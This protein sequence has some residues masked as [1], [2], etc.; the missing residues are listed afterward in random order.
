[1]EKTQKQLD[2][3]Q[4]LKR[5]GHSPEEWEEP[6]RNVYC[7]KCSVCEGECWVEDLTGDTTATGPAYFYTCEFILN[8]EKSQGYSQ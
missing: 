5:L 2:A 7:I 3:E 6:S 1:M 4:K 8:Y